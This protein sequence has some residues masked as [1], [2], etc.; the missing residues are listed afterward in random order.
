[1]L[2]LDD[3]ISHSRHVSDEQFNEIVDRVLDNCREVLDLL[4]ER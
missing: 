3:S 1:M 2:K 4:A